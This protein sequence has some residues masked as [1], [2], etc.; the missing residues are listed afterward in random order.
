MV[1]CTK[2]HSK[3]YSIDDKPAI[4]SSLSE[5]EIALD[6]DNPHEI[7]I[8]IRQKINIREYRGKPISELNQILHSVITNDLCLWP[9]TNE[10]CHEIR[11]DVDK[12]LKTPIRLQVQRTDTIY[13]LFQMRCDEDPC[14]FDGYVECKMDSIE[15]VLGIDKPIFLLDRWEDK[16][17]LKNWCRIVSPN[18]AAAHEDC[19]SYWE[20][21]SIR[22]LVTNSKIKRI[23]A[24]YSTAI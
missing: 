16:G 4:V 19:T 7:E 3:L 12:L 24:F 15:S 6:D 1:N 13:C 11:K 5:F 8:E 10:I 23:D 22:I 9:D 17:Y 14:R 21:V 18:T 20:D 2:K